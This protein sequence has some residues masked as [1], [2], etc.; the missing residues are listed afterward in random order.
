MLSIGGEGLVLG[1]PLTIT[2]YMGG[3][4]GLCNW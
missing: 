4:V 2:L 1:V 3:E